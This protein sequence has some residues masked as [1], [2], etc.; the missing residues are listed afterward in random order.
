[1]PAVA[2]LVDHLPSA[3]TTGDL[4]QRAPTPG[5]PHIGDP[6]MFQRFSLRR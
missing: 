6:N 2:A 4:D 5:N 3:S 1:M